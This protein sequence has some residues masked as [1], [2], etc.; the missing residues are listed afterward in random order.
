MSFGSLLSGLAT[1]LFAGGPIGAIAGVASSISANAAL[2]A[3]EASYEANETQLV[4]TNTRLNTMA[5][6]SSETTNTEELHV[7]LEEAH[8]H[9]VRSYIEAVKQTQ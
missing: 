3:S 6:R 1:G 9:V 4:Q 2:A 8:N 5:T 7:A